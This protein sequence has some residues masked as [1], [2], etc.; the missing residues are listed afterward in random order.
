MKIKFKNLNLFFLT[1]LF[2]S[3]M[4]VLI[5][6]FEPDIGIYS[7]TIHSISLVTLMIFGVSGFLLA[8]FEKA[9]IINVSYSEE[10]KRSVFYKIIRFAENINE[11]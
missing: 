11:K 8:V 9:K 5:Q 1:V 2:S 4:C 3:P 7:K 10:D 6:I